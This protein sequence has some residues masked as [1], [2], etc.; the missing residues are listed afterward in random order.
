MYCEEDARMPVYE[1]KCPDCGGFE[2]IRS[3]H[4]SR[5]DVVCPK[6]GNKEVSRVFDANVVPPP[7]AP[8][9]SKMDMSPGRIL[10]KAKKYS[11]TTG[12]KFPWMPNV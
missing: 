12:Q 10:D 2:I 5:K 11:E 4:D 3:I 9:V 6:C 7:A 8:R 1:Y